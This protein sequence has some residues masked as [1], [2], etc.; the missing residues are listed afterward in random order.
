MAAY[1][2]SLGAQGTAFLSL[3]AK[4][5]RE[6]L[7]R[8]DDEQVWWRPHEASNSIANLV[9]HVHGNL[10]LWILSSLGGLD[11]ERHRSREFTADHTMT[12]DQLLALLEDAVAE[13]GRVLEGLGESDLDRPFHVQR[14]DT[15]ARGIVFHA[16]EHMSYHTGQ[17][18]FITKQL[19]GAHHGIEFYPIHKDE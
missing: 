15:D 18:V 9:L 17:I 16:V 6:C 14:Y 11:F 1:R 3:Y 5:V 12:R 4:K 10:S 8:L 19:L 7:V 2:G 13:C